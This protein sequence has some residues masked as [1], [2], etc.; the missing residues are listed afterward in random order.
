[1][2][3]SACEVRSKSPRR[4]VAQVARRE[5]RQ[6]SEPHVGGRTAMG[7]FGERQLL[8]SSGGSQCSSAVTKVAKKAQV[9]RRV[10]AE[11]RPARAQTRF[12][13]KGRTAE[14]QARRASQQIGD[15]RSV[16][17]DFGQGQRE[18]DA[19]R[20]G[21]ESPRSTWTGTMR[22]DRHGLR[23]WTSE[24]APLEQTLCETS[25]LHAVRA[26]APRLK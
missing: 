5:V 17:N 8:E 7:D 20:S 21:E 14:H 18:V 12:A 2:D 15:R 25:I 24:E 26:I 3:P 23:S 13:R 9:L 16:R 22:R 6:K 4:N 11:S 10:G 19:C 1:M